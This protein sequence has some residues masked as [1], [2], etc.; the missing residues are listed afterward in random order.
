MVAIL[1]ILIKILISSALLFG[2]YWLFLRNKRFH[3]YNRYYLLATVVISLVLPFINIPIQVLPGSH[4]GKAIYN[5]LEVITVYGEGEEAVVSF[6]RLLP[7]WRFM[8]L[9]IYLA[10]SLV[11]LAGLLRS[12]F[13]IR[14]MSRNYPLE[15]V[16]DIK[17]YHTSEEGTPFSWFRRIFWNDGI[18]LHSR[19]GQ[20]IFRHELFHIRQCH[21]AD[22]LFLHLVYGVAW[23]NPFFFLIRNEIKTIHEFLADQHAMADQDHLEYAEILLEQS[24][25]ARQLQVTNHFFQHQIKRRITMIT[26]IQ[27]RNPGYI[28]RLLALPVVTFLT[29]VLAS[30]VYKNNQGTSPM[31]AAERI[32]I[33]LDAGHGGNDPG[34]T[35]ADGSISEQRL[36]LDI[37]RKIK[38]LAPAYNIEVELTRIDENLPGGLSN[39]NAANRW[40]VDFT[41][42]VNPMMFISIHINAAGNNKRQGLEIYVPKEGSKNGFREE[43]LMAASIM[44][45]ELGEY[46][47]EKKVLQRAGDRGIYVLDYN[48]VPAIMINPGFITNNG[49]LEFLRHAA[50]QEKIAR[51]ILEGIIA[52]QFHLD[53]RKGLANDQQKEPSEEPT[54]SVKALVPSQPNLHSQ[55]EMG[56]TDREGSH[57][58]MK[59]FQTDSL[60]QFPGGKEAWQDYLNKTLRYPQEA[61]DKEVMGTVLIQFTVHKDGTTSNHKIL[62]DPGAGLGAEALRVLKVSGKW[63]PAIRNGRK[64]KAIYQHPI[65][66]RLEAE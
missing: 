33:V 63:E 38:D 47:P 16:D 36:A 27:F 52:F 39:L 21:S 15:K 12:V 51:K 61:I 13:I 53:Q 8:A 18:L 20:Q 60:P 57:L 31:T 22:N 24:I 55:K 10:I 46:F 66:F 44:A 58:D 6:G 48:E 19:K 35:A 41:Q 3:Q 17:I 34:A 28:S 2:Y 1:I 11:I 14:K 25:R 37:V 62:K 7:D 40:R 64:V 54:E 23:F 59:V 29:L 49:D 56:S 9:G 30:F 65:T 45:K 26:N 4:M 32:K 43:S 42:S 50:N 5:T